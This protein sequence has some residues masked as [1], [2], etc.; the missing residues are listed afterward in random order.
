MTNRD[1]VWVAIPFSVLIA[2]SM[3]IL[4]S[5]FLEK[6]IISIQMIFFLAFGMGGGTLIAV[7]LD[8]FCDKDS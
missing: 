1:L 8:A 6:D 7:V 3:H 5:L 4:I 2:M